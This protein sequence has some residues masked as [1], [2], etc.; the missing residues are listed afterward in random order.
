MTDYFTT[1]ELADDDRSDRYAPP[2]FIRT[3]APA[4]RLAY[5]EVFENNKLVGVVW[6]AENSKTIPRAGIVLST[7]FGADQ[8]QNE[9]G[10]HSL[11][12]SRDT[13]VDATEWIGQITATR[14]GQSG[15]AVANE[16]YVQNID[17]LRSQYQ[18]ID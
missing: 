16:G 17:T 18:N 1:N 14:D 5:A 3:A 15:L 10:M 6:M 13:T 11:N 2:Q 7:I 12:Y 4:G 9:L 8:F